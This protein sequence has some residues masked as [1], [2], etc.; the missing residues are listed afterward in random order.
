[1]YQIKV[2]LQTGGGFKKESATELV[3][4]LRPSAGDFSVIRVKVVTWRFVI[5]L[6][7]SDERRRNA[8]TTKP[9]PLISM[10]A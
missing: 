2:L 4:I 7:M 10:T 8:M 1:M 3:Y 6:E 9:K 5:V